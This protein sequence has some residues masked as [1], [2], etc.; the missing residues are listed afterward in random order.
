MTDILADVSAR[1]YSV[2]KLSSK[3]AADLALAL[4]CLGVFLTAIIAKQIYVYGFLGVSEAFE[5]YIIPVVAASFLFGYVARRMKLYAPNAL[6]AP[7]TELY[8]VVEALAISLLVLVFA[9]YLMKF[10]HFFSRGW[11][12][13]WFMLGAIHLVLGRV[14]IARLFSWLTERGYLRHQIAVVGPSESASAL[15]DALTPANPSVKLAGIFALQNSSGDSEVANNKSIDS[16][17]QL[18]QRGAIDEIYIMAPLG[19]SD[20]VKRELQRLRVLPLPVKVC[21]PEVNLGMPIHDCETVGGF[22]AFSVQGKPI[23][24]WGIVLKAIEDRVLSSLALILLAPLFGLVAL[25]IKFD[26][27]GPVFFRQRRHGFNHKVINVWKFRTMSVTEDG[28]DVVQA[29]RNDPRVTAVGRFLRSTSLDELPQLMN[30]LR[31][32]MSLVG[33]RPH[34]IAHNKYYSELFDTYA[35]RHRVKPGITGWAQVNGFRGPTDDPEL[36]RQRV[37]YDQYYIEN[38]SLLFDLKI[39]LFTPIYGF[40]GRNAL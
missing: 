33:P 40:I 6:S 16:L 10:A 31:G 21:P 19:Q 38:W 32:E 25:A 22:T 13:T 34:A 29:K 14:I 1:E 4:D 35:T 36:M 7:R 12:L 37:A 26:S 15:M 2:G 9:G 20:D 8:R 3:I 23:S 27:R 5:R 24:E 30:V 11:M 17:V 18:G 28:N 39:L